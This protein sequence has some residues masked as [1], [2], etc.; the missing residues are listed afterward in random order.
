[1]AIEF[2][3]MGGGL[4]G[5]PDSEVFNGTLQAVRAEEVGYDG[6]VYVDSQN[7]VGDCYIAMA[8]AAQATS[9]IKLGTG[10]TNSFTRHPAVTASAIATVQVVSG[11]R[12]YL[13]I[14]RGDSAL[15]HL[16]RAP[17]PVAAFED[18][19]V[20]LQ[21][22]LRG[23]EVPF[24]T[25][26]DIDSL[27]LADYSGSSRIVW[28]AAAEPK[29]PVDVAATGPR[30]IAAA[31]RHADRVSLNVGADVERI[32]WGIEVARNAREK[33]GLSP[34]IPISAYLPLAVH[35]DPEEAMRIGAGQVSL[36]ARF[37]AMYGNVV[38]PAQKDQREVLQNI[39]SAYDMQ[40]HGRR[41]GPQEAAVTDE[42]ARS[43]GIFGPPTHCA[44]RL[45]ELIELGV[46]R[47]VLRGTPLDL[48]N[49]DSSAA[50][51]FIQEVVPLLRDSARP[52]DTK[53]GTP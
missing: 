16:G 28:T 52:R 17:H 1:M 39:Y 13:G 35:D 32:R 6:I 36:F 4:P 3:T 15:A 40:Q 41:H 49:P 23:E 27:G 42:F 30:V 12:A 24:E 45:S 34:E 8:L 38:G 46:D 51:R 43:F 20:R 50:E 44:D 53:T 25:G 48:A 31:A 19:L 18:Y 9:T 33:A 7:L 10:V 37:S 11:G 29:V 47:F 2:W 5:G 26:G 21:G 22:Y 14:G